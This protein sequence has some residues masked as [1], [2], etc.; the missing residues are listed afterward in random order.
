[1]IDMSRMFHKSPGFNQ[2]IGGWDTS[3]VTDMGG[4]FAGADAFNQDIGGWDTSSVTH[5][6]SMFGSAVVF[7]QNIGGWDTSGV[8]YMGSMFN[9]A[10]AFDQDLSGLEIQNVTNMWGMLSQSGLSVANYDATLM[11]W[12]Q[13]AQTTGV[14]R[15]V[16]LGADELLYSSQAQQARDGLI[17][18][19]GWTIRGDALWTPGQNRDPNAI[20]DHAVMASNVSVARFDVLANDRDEDG[21]SLTLTRVSVM[22]GGHG[23]ARINPDGTLTFIRAAGVRGQVWIAYDV[24][25]G[26]GGSD[27]SY[28]IVNVQEPGGDTVSNRPPT[29]SVPDQSGTAGTGKLL[30]LKPLFADA[31]GDTL[32]FA[33]AGTMPSGFHFNSTAGTLYA[34]DA[35]AAGSYDFTVQVDDGN[36][37][38]VSKGF[39]WTV[40]EALGAAPDLKNLS[41]VTS[42]Q[43]GGTSGAAELSGTMT[44]GRSGGTALLAFDGTVRV[45]N[46]SAIF[47]GNLFR[48]TAGASRDMVFDGT[49]TLDLDSLASSAMTGN[50]SLSMAGAGKLSPTGFVIENDRV[51]F[52]V[53]ADLLGLSSRWGA[54]NVSSDVALTQNGFSWVAG[55]ASV[56]FPSASITVPIAAFRLAAMVRAAAMRSRSSPGR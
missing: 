15:N 33:L 20:A 42:A 23:I 29:G 14:Q 27:T 17:N 55:N 45:E 1:M 8:T 41:L 30:Q 25:D 38:A 31:D 32:S 56:Q 13:Q 46:G 40:S 4:M 11:G 43:W 3:S 54:V 34:T 35:V 39:S 51:L 21:D 49:F 44:L 26:K 36:G 19:Y 53:K 28:L 18:D 7:N 5:M 48:T 10:D 47:D 37:G 50:S 52:D 9:G 16:Q 2:D 22:D 24:S 12:Y 6:G